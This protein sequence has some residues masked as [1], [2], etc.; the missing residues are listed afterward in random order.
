[1]V[2]G[3]YYTDTTF[4]GDLGIS[5]SSTVD[6]YTSFSQRDPR[7]E[8]V[9]LGLSYQTMGAYGCL[10]TSIASMLADFGVDTDPGRLNRWLARNGGFVNGNLM[11]FGALEK[12]GVSLLDL[13]DCSTRPAP[14]D[15]I[16]QAML[17]GEGVVAMVDFNPGGT[18]NQ[19]WVRS[20]RITDDDALIMD[21][22]APPGYEVYWLMARYAQPAWN[23]P[24]RALFRVAI[25]GL[26]REAELRA[27]YSDIAGIG[28]LM[29]FAPASR[30]YQES[31]YRRPPDWLRKLIG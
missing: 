5:Y 6:V 20:L 3:L 21:P 29:A 27:G 10:V 26:E 23:D 19:H 18:V 1:M 2:A 4:G 14:M 25:Y 16:R 30:A 8:S 15:R 12:F 17:S 22:W 28:A 9:R 13:V 24:S 31:L 7:W 11:V